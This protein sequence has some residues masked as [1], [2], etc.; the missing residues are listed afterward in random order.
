MMK[1]LVL[2]I[3]V[4]LLSACAP[5]PQAI[6]T[7]VASTQEAWPTQTPYPTYTLLP[8]YTEIPTA[9]ATE[10]PTPTDTPAPTMTP[11]SALVVG[12]YGT[13]APGELQTYADSHIGE[14][15][16]VILTITNFTPGTNNEELQGDI[17]GNYANI[18]VDLV[19]PPSG[20]YLGDTIT[21]YGTVNGNF[22]YVSTAGWNMTEPQIINAFYTKP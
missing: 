3:I 1:P 4:I 17:A 11:P 21:V 2:F 15:V 7:A 13:I 10:G 22:S 19:N 9:T 6:Q 18:I 8:T 14:K 20:I 5:S 16:K 12:D